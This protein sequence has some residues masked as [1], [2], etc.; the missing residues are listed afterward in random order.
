MEKKTHKKKDKHDI[1]QTEL[2]YF[3]LYVILGLIF[4]T[5]IVLGIIGFGGWISHNNNNNELSYCLEFTQQSLEMYEHIFVQQSMMNGFGRIII[6]KKTLSFHYYFE[7][8]KNDDYAVYLKKIDK[9]LTNENTILNKPSISKIIFPLDNKPLINT[10][11]NSNEIIE[12][13]DVIPISIYQEFI[14]KPFKFYF[15][16]ISRNYPGGILVSPINKRC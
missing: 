8:S 9:S 3:A 14:E 1:E 6:N 13:D 12:G 11:S 15:F 2:G 7:F 4:L 10:L 16:V 5:A